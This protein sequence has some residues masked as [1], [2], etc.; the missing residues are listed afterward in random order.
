MLNKNK[1]DLEYLLSQ[2]G[3]ELG[4]DSTRGEGGLIPHDPEEFDKVIDNEENVFK[5][6]QSLESAGKIMDLIDKKGRSRYGIP[7][8]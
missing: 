2:L 6:L 5:L 8:I 7:Q 4:V 3:E 1:G